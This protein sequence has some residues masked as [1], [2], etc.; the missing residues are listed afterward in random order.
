MSTLV[1]AQCLCGTNKYHLSFPTSSLPI[2][3]SICN[4]NTCRHATGQS[5]AMYVDLDGPPLSLFSTET[6]STGET[7]PAV[8]NLDEEGNL[9]T[10]ASSEGGKRYFCST[11]GAHMFFSVEDPKDGKVR[12]EACAGVLERFDGIV[13]IDK[14][15]FL[16]DTLDGGASK[17]I[18][19]YG[20]N[21]LPRY[22]ALR[23]PGD[24][25]PHDWNHTPQPSDTTTTPSNDLLHFHCLCKSI[26]FHIERPT[27]ITNPSEEWWFVPGKTPSDPIR[28]STEYCFCTSCR[29]SSGCV[30]TTWSYVPFDCTLVSSECPSEH[31]K[32]EVK[33][34]HQP[35]QKPD[36]QL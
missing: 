14:H 22:K 16:G 10:Y 28:Y 6:S 4:C 24:A 19:R 8:A 9:T 12:W 15:I 13:T 21:T 1:K 33:H 20:G 27:I 2:P 31:N 36:H 34:I 25:L 35:T 7:Q 29:L 23:S 11:C 5:F 30:V 18:T 26:S 3:T 32:L 17:H